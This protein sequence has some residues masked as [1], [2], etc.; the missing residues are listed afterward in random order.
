M[1]GFE[2]TASSVVD[3]DDECGRTKYGEMDNEEE[4]EESEEGGGVHAGDGLGDGSII[5]G[6]D[7]DDLGDLHGDPL[8]DA[9]SGVRG[10]SGSGFR[11]DDWDRVSNE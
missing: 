11:W 4:S 10:D 7:L 3:I 5:A 8:G 1:G 6:G 2:D 9:G